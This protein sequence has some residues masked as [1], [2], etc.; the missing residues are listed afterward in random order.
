MLF[1]QSYTMPLMA[2]SFAPML[3][4]PYCPIAKYLQNFA[5]N[6]AGTGISK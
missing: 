6:N 5:T 1:F 3:W 4:L 2:V